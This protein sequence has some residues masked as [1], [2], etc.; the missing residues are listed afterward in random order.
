MRLFIREV[1]CLLL[2]AVANAEPLLVSSQPGSATAEGGNA[3]RQQQDGEGGLWSGVASFLQGY[4]EKATTAM[5]VHH[6]GLGDVEQGN[7]TRDEIAAGTVVAA[8]SQATTVVPA[9]P[10]VIAGGSDGVKKRPGR[11]ILVG[12]GKSMLKK[13]LGAQIDSFDV[14][15][16]YNYIRLKGHTPNVGR[17]VTLWFLGE[18]K[19]P[20]A[21]EFDRSIHPERYV[22]PITWPATKGCKKCLPSKAAR[23]NAERSTMKVKKKWQ[24][25]GLSKRLEIMP[26]EVLIDLRL[27]YGYNQQ[28]PSTGLISVVY[29]LK[30][31]NP[32]IAVTG[33]DFGTAKKKDCSWTGCTSKV[34]GH[35]FQKNY[36]SHTVHNMFAEGQFMKML[37][38][39][40][41]VQVI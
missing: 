16:R 23:K 35:W 38:K 29:A 15:G 21:P 31:Y 30:Y 32:P 5:P 40:G 36:K 39:R 11:V 13:K 25:V 3:S 1:L 7:A 24:A 19:Q 2:V 26:D 41:L 22:V 34:L 4:M 37:Q 17:K 9:H 20:S 33:F 10:Q 8:I 28:W 14:V 27:K 18:L 6:V 12:N